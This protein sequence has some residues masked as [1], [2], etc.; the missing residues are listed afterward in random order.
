MVSLRRL[1]TKGG[2]LC[3]DHYFKIEKPEEL[4]YVESDNG[5]LQNVTTFDG[6]ITLKFDYARTTDSP[7]NSTTIELLAKDQNGSAAAI[8]SYEVTDN[9]I[10]Q[11]VLDISLFILN[12]DMTGH[13]AGRVLVF[14]E[15]GLQDGFYSSISNVK[16]ELETGISFPVP[17]AYSGWMGLEAQSQVAVGSNLNA[18]WGNTTVI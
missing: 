13:L 12:P 6:N 1:F 9:E 3:L 5:C 16:V 2:L 17:L 14:D 4:V 7:D 15:V 10:H 18:N 8:A 11:A